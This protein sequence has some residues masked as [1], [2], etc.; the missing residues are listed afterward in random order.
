MIDY[1][2]LH[3]DNLT[4]AQKEALTEV[5]RL[6]R[7]ES[8]SAG[9]DARGVI[10]THEDGTKFIKEHTRLYRQTWILPILNTMLGVT[11]EAELYR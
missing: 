11:N 3:G 9:F 1:D 4:Q 7:M 2:K 10:N 5:R 8:F 6:I